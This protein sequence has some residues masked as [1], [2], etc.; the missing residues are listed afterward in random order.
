M[1][2][3][4][5]HINYTA[6]DFE[7]YYNGS[8]PEAEMYALEKAALEDPFLADALEGYAFTATPLQDIEELTAQVP[9][10]KEEDKKAVVVGFNT[11]WLRIAA[12]LVL[13]LGIGYLLLKTD[14]KDEPA[15]TLASTDTKAVI[16]PADNKY[17]NIQ[18][19]TSSVAT[20]I[21]GNGTTATEKRTLPSS[22]ATMQPVNGAFKQLA[23]AAVPAVD[24][25][26]TITPAP[27]EDAKTKQEEKEVSLAQAKVASDLVKK[28]YQKPGQKYFLEGKVTDDDGT[29]VPFATVSGTNNAVTVT[30]ANG[31]FSLQAN[32]SLLLANISATGYAAVNQNFNLNNQQSIT[33]KKENNNLSEVVV[34][35]L[36]TERQK[37]DLGYAT[38]KVSAD[39]VSKGLQ[40]KVSGLNI[41]PVDGMSRYDQYI[42]S[43]RQRS[44]LTK[45]PKGEVTLSFKVNKKGEP[46]A[47]KV[48]KS[49]APAQDEEAIRLLKQG[50]KWQYSHGRRASKSFNF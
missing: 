40:G 20:I 15:P 44:Q 41:Q 37:K 25:A 1:A 2:N 42:D 36:G 27:T 49:L 7:R 50:P 11:A 29:P 45:A 23:P 43:A 24:Y 33:L 28:M 8:M 22:N 14:R 6:A 19:D 39:E 13:V 5:Q 46:I 34:T 10:A 12:V 31:N 21:K 48:Q 47:I 18:T 17:K 38:Q 26:Y 35:G 30:D 16:S 32:D 4:H 3:G 9:P